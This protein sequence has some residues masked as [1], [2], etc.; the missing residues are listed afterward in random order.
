ML[1]VTGPDRGG[2]AAWW[3]T[4]LAIWRAG[5][6]CRRITPSRPSGI[7]GLD[8]LILGGGADVAPAL[9]GA[10]PLPSPEEMAV[11]ETGVVRRLAAMVTF[12]LLFLIRRVLTTRNPGLNA[13]RDELELGLLREA[14]ARDLPVLGICR[15]AQLINVVLGGSLHQHLAGFYGE[16]PNIRS[17]LP[18]KKI[19]VEKD[20]RL[21]RILG[22]ETCRVNALHDQAID[23]PGEDVR[24]VAMEPS[25]V[26]QAVEVNGKRLVLGVQWHPEYLPLHRSQARLF[27]EFVRAARRA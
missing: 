20:S 8:G 1:G 19:R 7:E 13:K 10:D 11:G 17:L 18:R 6:A 14:L 21:V 26:V 4:C 16:S 27:E 2:L 5:G 25:G 23:R 12:P 3:F 9:Y 22:C 15:G 24:I